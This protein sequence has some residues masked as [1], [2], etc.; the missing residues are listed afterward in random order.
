[1]LAHPAGVSFGDLVLENLDGLVGTPIYGGAFGPEI[2][3]LD[4]VS[5]RELFSDAELM[6]GGGASALTPEEMFTLLNDVDMSFAGDVILASGAE[7]DGLP[8]TFATEYLALPSTAP[9]APEP[10]TWAMLLIG[11]GGLGLVRY[12]AP[13]ASKALRTRA[14]RLN[15]AV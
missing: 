15:A 8:D 6:L 10:S 12:Q 3:G 11:F 1:V 5:V 4:G 7:I 2:A 9:T 13:R 14:R